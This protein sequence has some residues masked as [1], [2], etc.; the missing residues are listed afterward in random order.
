V[1]ARINHDGVSR[2][3]AGQDLLALS[4]ALKWAVRRRLIPYNSLVGYE[5]DLQK[6]TRDRV[7]TE[8]EIRAMLSAANRLGHVQIFAVV[9]VMHWSAIRPKELVKTQYRNVDFAQ[10]W[11]RVT[12]AVDKME[13]GRIATLMPEGAAALRELPR[14]GTD[15][16]FE[17]SRA[18]NRPFS[19]ATL[20]RQWHNVVDVAGLAPNDD[21]KCAELYSMRHTLATKLAIDYNLGPYELCAYMG[22]K[23]VAQAMTYVKAQERQLVATSAKLQAAR[24][25]AHTRNP[26]SPSSRQLTHTEPAIAPKGQK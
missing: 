7:F 16:L 8:P 23:N 12:P 18:P 26:M 10:G 11:I 4:S 1:A 21:G 15:W 24:G 13:R 9:A 17:S 22:W 20:N 2:S 25:D 6:T 19:Y 5:F 14:K 3:T